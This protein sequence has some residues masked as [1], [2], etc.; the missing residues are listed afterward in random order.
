MLY[1]KTFTDFRIGSRD[2]TNVYWSGIIQ[3]GRM[4]DGNYRWINGH[5]TEKTVS[6]IDWGPGQPNGKHHQKCVSAFVRQPI[7]GFFDQECS[8]ENCAVCAFPDSQ[9]FFLRGLSHGQ[10]YFDDEFSLIMAFQ[11]DPAVLVFD[12][13]MKSKLIWYFDDNLAVLKSEIHSMNVTTKDNPIG[14]ANWMIGSKI[15]PLIFTRVRVYITTRKDHWFQTLKQCDPV[16]F[17]TCNDGLCIGLKQKCDGVTNCP[18]G[19]DEQECSIVDVKESLYRKVQPPKDAGGSSKLPIRV[20]F[21]IKSINWIDEQKLSYSI[22]FSLLLNWFETRLNYFDLKD[23]LLENVIGSEVGKNLWVPPLTFVNSIDLK[24]VSYNPQIN[25]LFVQK[26]EDGALAGTEALH[27]ALT[28]KGDTN[29]I[30]FKG[31]Y[32]MAFSCTFNLIQFPFDSQQCLAS[33]KV[34]EILKKQ[35]RLEPGGVSYA[36]K[37]ILTQFEVVGTEIATF[38]NHTVGVRFSLKRICV[39]YITSV[40]IPSLCL[41][42]A[43]EVTLFIDESHFE[44]TIM[45]ALTSTLVMYTLYNSISASLPIDA[46]FKMIDVWLLHGLLM[47]FVVFLILIISELTAKNK[48]DLSKKQFLP[49]KRTNKVLRAGQITIPTFS[50]IFVVVFFFYSFYIYGQ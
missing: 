43:A 9:R 11:R 19:S 39:Y 49:V 17:F 15:F 10:E 37:S 34:P 18:D 28:F 46:N 36:G 3:D 6:N 45:V 30:W 26:K 29:P 50:G 8:E 32:D 7:G 41:I 24:S 14:R 31:I 48:V 2:C 13:S 12:G 1:S 38:D 42:I 47:P 23:D 4:D 5:D 20:S 44:V 16:E 25:T 33:L 21:G 22:R 27:E 40:F 35:L